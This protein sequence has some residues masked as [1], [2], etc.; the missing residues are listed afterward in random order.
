VLR[1]MLVCYESILTGESSAFLWGSYWGVYMLDAQCKAC[2]YGLA[3]LFPAPSP[4][5]S[6]SCD[7]SDVGQFLSLWGDPCLTKSSHRCPTPFLRRFS[8]E[9]GGS[10]LW[11]RA[12]CWLLRMG[13]ES[14]CTFLLSGRHELGSSSSGVLERRSYRWTNIF[15]R[16]CCGFF[17][18][19]SC[20]QKQFTGAA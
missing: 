18:Q 12:R 3:M 4:K 10:F 17:R 20:S 19:S 6:Q 16:S 11:Q 7:R 15:L 8:A 14:N 2:H 13:S 9:L 1:Q 5:R